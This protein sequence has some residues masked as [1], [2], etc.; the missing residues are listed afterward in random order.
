MTYIQEFGTEAH[1]ALVT[2]PIEIA[3]NQI[4][5]RAAELAVYSSEEMRD[6]AEIPDKFVEANLAAADVMDRVA[7]ALRQDRLIIIGEPRGGRGILLAPAG[8]SY[9]SMPDLP[10]PPDARPLTIE[11]FNR[12]HGAPVEQGGDPTDG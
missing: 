7:L 2:T 6:E 12:M 10:A 3:A 11:E 5:L 9:R 1:S 4:A 8:Q